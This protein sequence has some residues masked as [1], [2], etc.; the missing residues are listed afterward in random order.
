MYNIKKKDKGKYCEVNSVLIAN[1]TAKPKN[2]KETS[3]WRSYNSTSTPRRYF[4]AISKIHALSRY[5]GYYVVASDKV[6]GTVLCIWS[7]EKKI[8]SPTDTT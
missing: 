2:V 5:V 7:T 4:C 6:A 1:M 3:R 8:P